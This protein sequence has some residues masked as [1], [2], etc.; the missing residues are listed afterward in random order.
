MRQ[1]SLTGFALQP[2]GLEELMGINGR[3][4]GTQDA[5]QGIASQ[6]HSRSSRERVAVQQN[7]AP[8]KLNQNFEAESLD[9]DERKA[10]PA[11]G[12]VQTGLRR[13]YKGDLRLVPDGPYRLDGYCF[14]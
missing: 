14:G 1:A 4:M 3:A 11:L 6:Q 9:T 10:Y 7:D 2:A 8:A 13:R 5:R 12:R